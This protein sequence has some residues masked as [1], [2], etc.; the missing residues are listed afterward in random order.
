MDNTKIN[1]ILAL[2]GFLGGIIFMILLIK[3]LKLLRRSLGFLKKLYI[4]SVFLTSILLISCCVCGLIFFIKL[5]LFYP[6]SK[7]IGVT[8]LIF[9]IVFAVGILV[10]FIGIGIAA[11][12]VA[13]IINKK[14]EEK[15]TQ[16]IGRINQIIITRNS[17]ITLL[18]NRQI[19]VLVLFDKKIGTTNEDTDD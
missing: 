15:A 11:C 6:G 19:D 10:G 4:I 9:S 8:S 14:K 3:E 1:I 18:K 2:V 5:K 7:F 16:E 17:E 12:N 13:E